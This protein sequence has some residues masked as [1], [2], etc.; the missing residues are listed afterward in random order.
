VSL[1]EIFHTQKY[2]NLTDLKLLN[3]SVHMNYEDISL[4]KFDRSILFR[5]LKLF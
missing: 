5:V 4:M 1:R 3:I 2:L